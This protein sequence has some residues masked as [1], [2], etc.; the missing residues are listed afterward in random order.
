MNYLI[1]A[2]KTDKKLIQKRVLKCIYWALIQTEY[3]LKLKQDKRVILE[4]QIQLLIQSDD[5]S[6]CNTSKE[7]FK[8]LQ[9]SGSQLGA[10]YEGG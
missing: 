7:I 2:L 4:Q 9:E 6:I 1:T 8:I 5:R 10:G 3:Q